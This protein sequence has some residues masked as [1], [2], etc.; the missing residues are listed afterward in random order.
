[1][2]GRSLP[3]TFHIHMDTLRVPRQLSSGDLD[4]PGLHMKKTMLQFH[5]HRS[6]SFVYSYFHSDGFHPVDEHLV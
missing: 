6:S 4:V 5:S 1:M 3:H 2:M